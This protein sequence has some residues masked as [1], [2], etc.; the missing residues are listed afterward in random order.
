MESFPSKNEIKKNSS[1]PRSNLGLIGQ[2]LEIVDSFLR[3][4]KTVYLLLTGLLASFVWSAGNL[5]KLS[6]EYSFK[7]FY[8]ENHQILA[9]DSEVKKTFQINERSPFLYILELP[10]HQNWLDKAR[11]K[12]LQ[13]LNK[14]LSDFT[15]V[16]QAVTMTSIEGAAMSKNEIVIGNF[17]DRLPEK[18]W[19]S[20]VVMNSL[21]Y[22]L[23]LSKDFRTTIVAIYTEQSTSAQLK[24]WEQQFRSAVQKS[25]PQAKV[26]SAGVPVMQTQLTELIR[27]ELG[28]FFVVAIAVFCFL[29]Y[30][31]FSHW[32]AVVSAFLVLLVAQVFSLG[33]LI[34]LKV[35]MNVILSTLPIIVSVSVMSL[36]IHT[37]HLWSM[38]R[39]R[40]PFADF[41]SKW[42][43]S[44]D[45]L[46]D[47]ALPNFLGSLT[48]AFGFLALVPSD[49]PIIKQYGW[50]VCLIV[51]LISVFGQALVLVSLPFVQPT[52]RK[53]FDRPANWAIFSIRHAKPI[54]VS[55]IAISIVSTIGV[56]WLN[57]SG[58]LFTDLP[59]K[60]ISQMTTQLLDKKNGGLV[61]YDLVL[62]S[63]EMDFF[64]KHENLVKL[65][66]LT[67][68]LRQES[69]VG[70]VVALPDLFQGQ[71]PH[72]QKAISESLFLFS[73]A[74][75]NPL[76][77]FVTE[78]ARK[79]RL[80]VRF[81]DQPG[82]AIA[83]LRSWVKESILTYFPEIKVSESGMAVANHSINQMVAK[84]LVYSF[85]HPL[86]L[87]GI[88]LV[89]VFKSL[90]WAIVACIPNLIPPVVLI[91]LMA[92][93]GVVIKPSVALV[94]AIALGFA[95][96]NTIYLLSRLRK[97]KDLIETL[98]LEANPC[99]FESVVMFFGFSVFAL[100]Q[101]TVNQLFGI[102]MMISILI[103]FV[104][105]LMFLPAMITLFPK[106]LKDKDLT[107]KNEGTL[108]KVASILLLLSSLSYAVKTS[109]VTGGSLTAN[110]ILTKSQK[111]LD[112]KDDQAQV[113]LKIIEK[114]G[115]EKIR[116]V[117]MK[118]YRGKTFSVIAKIQSP[119]DVKGM[120]FLGQVK[121][122]EESQ[123]IYLPS[124]KQVRRVV[125][126]KSKG[127]L[128]G[129]EISSEDL[130]TTAVKNAKTKLVKSEGSFY[131]IEVIPKKGTSSYSK[132]LSYI[133]KE[134]FLPAKAEYFTG[135]KMKKLVEFSDY[136]KIGNI[137]RAQKISVKNLLNGRKTEVLFSDMRV[138]SG[139]SSSD[140]TQNSLKSMR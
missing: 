93:S 50:V 51:C 70:S 76:I 73:M 20:E 65:N 64:K 134:S 49:I 66:S 17:F 78:D 100:S 61:T 123:W 122:G 72:D 38:R 125:T 60:N 77:G 69:A 81:S 124:S 92:V 103:G 67:K 27:S 63:K 24:L 131:L 56:H 84:D 89:I 118:T 121:N 45:T 7:Q 94:F 26:T 6:T 110:Q 80:M 41:K 32:T 139:L 79:T 99:A 74:E 11:V 91:G 112:A 31:L 22:P 138:N 28:I 90:R 83:E 19:K 130:N 113:E 102:F 116:K 107:E 119:P 47:L 18:K 15:G 8:P 13:N 30:A 105:D 133:S 71:L 25:F 33:I 68:H 9:M 42:S 85:W 136:K 111:Q 4:S 140:F 39:S 54:F 12:R 1:N 82:K 135:K 53:W 34:P 58:R 3:S 128:L 115:E 108:V 132:V 35:P 52:M 97:K 98:K 2:G 87:I 48:T 5:R 101:F 46:K 21:I 23:F 88:F 120:G 40:E 10:S 86:I 57:F 126:G 55:V 16:Q 117:D 96:N 43:A 109:A 95:F 37:F 106:L 114:N 29:F 137:Y 104:G 129:S 36:L 59:Q 75:K 62:E 14:K 127:G 44:I